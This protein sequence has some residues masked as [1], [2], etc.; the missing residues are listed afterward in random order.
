VLPKPSG[1]ACLCSN[2]LH[3]TDSL[4]SAK[5]ISCWNP[6][7]T[8][9]SLAASTRF[10]QTALYECLQVSRKTL[11]RMRLWHRAVTG[12]AR[13]PHSVTTAKAP[14][15]VSLTEDGCSAE[16]CGGQPGALHAWL[17]S[18]LLLGQL[19][20]HSCCCS[21][22]TIRPCDACK[23]GYASKLHTS[24]HHALSTNLLLGAAC[25]QWD[26]PP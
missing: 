1:R 3:G 4:C 10:D 11:M 8:A 13:D 22:N 2:L 24:Q 12:S 26:P 7:S 17:P 14:P 18:A 19:L 9:H 6:T 15:K 16:V 23:P 25:H 5:T 21:H 20:T